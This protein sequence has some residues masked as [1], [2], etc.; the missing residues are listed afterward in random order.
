M[1]FSRWS[2]HLSIS[3]HE[4]WST[5]IDTYQHQ[6]T[7]EVNSNELNFIDRLA[8]EACRFRND[9]SNIFTNFEFIAA[10]LF[11]T[12]CILVMVQGNHTLIFKHFNL[13]KSSKICILNNRWFACHRAISIQRKQITFE[14]SWKSYQKLTKT[15]SRFKRTILYK[16]TRIHFIAS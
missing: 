4:S 1:T 7:R 16:I 13:S 14:I 5:S 9:C 15:L 6:I 8:H 2:I 11:Q 10:S 3:R 12:L